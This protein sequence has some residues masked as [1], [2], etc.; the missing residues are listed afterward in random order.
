MYLWI[1]LAIFF[2]FTIYLSFKHEQ[3]IVLFT[4]I[5]LIFFVV[6]SAIV[7]EYIQEVSQKRF[8][9]IPIEGKY[10]F[11]DNVV[12]IKNDREV[13]KIYPKKVKVTEEYKPYVIHE[14]VTGTSSWSIFPFVSDEKIL[15]IPIFNPLKN[16]G[17][18]NDSQ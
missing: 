13:L 15:Y 6:I 7:N 2:A 14:V 9:V 1:I 18:E 16:E 3:P 4:F 11:D 10:I 17:P 8:E 12:F 5:P